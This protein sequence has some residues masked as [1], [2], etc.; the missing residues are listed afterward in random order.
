MLPNRLFEYYSLIDK[1]VITKNHRRQWTLT[2]K[3]KKI[4]AVYSSSKLSQKTKYK[5]EQI[6]RKE[7][8]NL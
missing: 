8:K 5:K 4:S 1:S 2:T 6:I 3:E 7:K